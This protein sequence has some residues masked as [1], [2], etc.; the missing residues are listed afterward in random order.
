MGMCSRT[1]TFNSY[2]KWTCQNAFPLFIVQLNFY[3]KSVNS[4]ISWMLWNFGVFCFLRVLL[5]SGCSAILAVFFFIP[6]NFSFFF[7]CVFISF[8]V[9]IYLFILLF[10]IESRKRIISTNEIIF[11]ECNNHRTIYSS[12]VCVCV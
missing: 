3:W 6:F 5:L 8:Y 10:I 2:V 1:H 7:L 4:L 9:L 12:S 11:T